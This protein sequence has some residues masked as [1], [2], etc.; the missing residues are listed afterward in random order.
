[1]FSNWPRSV[2]GNGEGGGGGELER[3]RR[4]GEAGGGGTTGPRPARLH[5]WQKDNAAAGDR[6]SFIFSGRC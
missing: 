1:M 5:V 4:G 6:R 3:P 2:Q